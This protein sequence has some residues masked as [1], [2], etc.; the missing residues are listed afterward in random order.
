MAC[1]CPE[2]RISE[3][4]KYATPGLVE[5]IELNATGR[6]DHGN[7]N[8][9]FLSMDANA[10]RM[11]AYIFK[12]Y[13]PNLLA[14]H[15]ASVDGMGHGYGR[16]ASQVRL[17][18]AN[19]DNGVGV[20]LEAVERSGLKDST[21]VIVVGDH[22]MSTIHSA[23]RPNIWI[24]DLK[25]RFL[26][27]GGSCFL[28]LDNPGDEAS[29]R[30]VRKRL[31]E[32]D[33]KY[34]GLFRIYEKSELEAEGADRDAVLALVAKKGYTFSGTDT[35]RVTFPVNGGQHGYHPDEPEMHT[36]FIACGPGVGKG[37]RSPLR[38]TDI[39]PLVA[40]RLGVMRGRRRAVGLGTARPA[41]TSPAPF[42]RRILKRIPAK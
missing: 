42:S 18:L 3:S 5:E 30:A 20:V 31:E 37:R 6:L 19:A 16:N 40:K 9:E 41:L 21:T 32:L 29:L 28:H 12:K 2:D 38:I 34:R 24:K 15:F 14:L 39:A 7:M 13:R 1:I 8:E 4:R 25:A 27:A 22:G 10:A 23:V 26:S 11:A 17:A 36:G 35:G 33:V